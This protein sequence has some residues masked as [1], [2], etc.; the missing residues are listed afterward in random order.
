MKRLFL[1]IMILPIIFIALFLIKVDIENYEHQLIQE[2]RKEEI[3]L[4]FVGD[5]MLDRGVYGYMQKNNDFRWPFLKVAGLLNQGD[6]VFGNLESVIS[7]KGHN[8]GSIYS[9]RADP[10]TIQGLSLA[11]FNV[12]SVANNHAFDYTR[13]AFEDS[14][15]RLK[16]NNISYV[17]GGM[18]EEESLSLLIKEVQNTKIGFLGYTSIGLPNW[19]AIENTPGIA[20]IDVNRIDILKEKIKEVKKQVDYL[21]VSFHFGE[22]YEKTPN[23]EQITLSR[24]AID[25]GADLI[26]GHHPHVV[27]PIERYKNKIIA[28][29][30]GNFIFDQ[31]FSEETMNSIILKIIIQ[32]KN[33]IKT[34]IIPIKQNQ[35]L[36]VE[37]K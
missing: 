19:Q 25:S 32:D 16:E 27:Q 22:E 3:T 34:E 17:G 15:K 31:T 23:P 21:I 1:W 13:E 12:V 20:W 7:D 26:I 33:I 4:F 28:Y 14:L 29:S 37:L 36:Q 18:N 10:E 8:I 9:F 30:L 24:S 5:I 35:F 2:S 6:I 11:N